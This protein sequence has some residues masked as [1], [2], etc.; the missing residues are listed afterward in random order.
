M[1]TV[2][3]ADPGDAEAICGVHVA[4]ISAVE[5]PA[6]DDDQVLAWA[7]SPT[8]EQYPIEDDGSPVFVAEADGDV[9]GF[10]ELDAGEAAVEKVYVH[11]GHAGDG[12]GTALLSRVES[13]A[14]DRGLAELSVVSSL[15]AVPFYEAVGYEQVGE[16]AKTVAG[17][18]EFP[19][20]VFERTLE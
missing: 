19:C 20:A 13:A 5:S 12:V 9:V 15:N 7:S 1:V 2:R 16:T 17:D 8:P 18:V 14:A 4:A 3:H 10:A 11:P 6:Y